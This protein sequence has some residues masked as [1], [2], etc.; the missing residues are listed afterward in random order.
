MC[1]NQHMTRFGSL[2]TIGVVAVGLV[3]GATLPAA[4]RVG[5]AEHPSW[6]EYVQTHRDFVQPGLPYVSRVPPDYCDLPS[7]GCQSYLSN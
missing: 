2:L 4:A 6:G 1:K 7:A 3:A 5:A